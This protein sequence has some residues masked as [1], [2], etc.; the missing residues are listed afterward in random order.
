MN[1][2]GAESLFK[3]IS[4]HVRK[5]VLSHYGNGA[6]YRPGQSDLVNVI[7][8]R[9]IHQQN[10]LAGRKLICALPHPLQRGGDAAFQRLIKAKLRITEFMT[11]WPPKMFSLK[12]RSPVVYLPD[13]GF[14][15]SNFTCCQF[16]VT[17]LRT[18]DR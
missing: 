12:K 14:P 2:V 15:S 13:N 16:V 4:F 9:V 10:V 7:L 6:I 17:R 18:E 3:P 1:A 5:A 8:V 11:V